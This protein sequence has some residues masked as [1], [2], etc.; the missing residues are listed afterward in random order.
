[1][2]MVLLQVHRAHE[3]RQA[4][5]GTAALGAGDAEELEYEVAR[6]RLAVPAGEGEWFDDAP[7]AGLAEDDVP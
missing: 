2:E 4:E 5:A 3:L 7:V 1:M 6:A